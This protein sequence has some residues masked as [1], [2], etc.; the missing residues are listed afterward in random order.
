V[1]GEFEAGIPV[2]VLKQRPAVQ[3]GRVVPGITF[4]QKMVARAGSM[5]KS[6]VDIRP[7]LAPGGL[8]E[9]QYGSPPEYLNVYQAPNLNSPALRTL[10]PGTIV[11]IICKGNDSW[12]QVRTPDGVVGW[13]VEWK[14]EP[15]DESWYL[16]LDGLPW[17]PRPGSPVP[18]PRQG[19]EAAPPSE[20]SF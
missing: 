11:R 13:M 9:I 8:A 19:A 7:Q 20:K 10:L 5:G 4:G 18:G 14:I 1:L 16:I 3:N 2:E 15:T 17:A 12:W 6:L